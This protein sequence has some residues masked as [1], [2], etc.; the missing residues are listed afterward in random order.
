MAPL[1]WPE[2]GQR[3]IVKLS[4]EKKIE[5]GIDM[6]DDFGCLLPRLVMADEFGLP[7]QICGSESVVQDCDS[8]LLPK[9]ESASWAGTFFYSA[10]SL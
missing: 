8:A 10:N 6:L 3:E 9:S 4:K 5:I 7:V 2:I 1:C